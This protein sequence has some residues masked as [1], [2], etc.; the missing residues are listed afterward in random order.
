MTKIMYFINRPTTFLFCIFL[1]YVLQGCTTTTAL[2]MQPA[3]TKHHHKRLSS[4]LPR[5]TN[6]FYKCTTKY[7]TATTSALYE[8]KNDEGE[9]PKSTTTTILDRFTNPRIDDPWLPIN[10]AGLVQI[11]APTLQ[12]FWLLSM[13]SSFPSWAT[14]LF[15]YTFAPRGAFLAPTLIHG[16]Y[17]PCCI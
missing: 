12:L 17:C 6:S 15:D 13:G 4:S 14:P 3:N 11:V 2:L 16:T 9:T 1:L 5:Q 8:K 7:S 10:E